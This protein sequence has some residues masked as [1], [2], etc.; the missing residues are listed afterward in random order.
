MSEKVKVLVKRITHIEPIIIEQT[1]L[2][3][4]KDQVDNIDAH[5]E[6]AEP[7]FHVLPDFIATKGVE[8]SVTKIEA[9]RL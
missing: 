1:V 3:V 2:E 6:A 4:E 5:I 8:R 9:K 7:G